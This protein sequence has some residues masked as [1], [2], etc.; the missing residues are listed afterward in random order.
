[1]V[2]PSD[3]HPLS[4]FLRDHEAHLARLHQTG[5]PE[6]LTVDG[7]AQIVVQDAEAYQQL[8]ELLDTVDADRVL[9]QRLASLDRDEAGV[10][11]DDVLAAV[12]ARLG[13]DPD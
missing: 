10:P 3:I 5:R 2:H 1:M 13:L 9:R 6:V 7:R 8:I 11:A 12:K 4:G